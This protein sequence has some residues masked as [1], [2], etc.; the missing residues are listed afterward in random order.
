MAKSKNRDYPLSETPKPN[1]EVYG[2]GSNKNY[3]MGVSVDVPIYK[4]LSV[5]ANKFYGKDDYGN[6]F[7]NT[8]YNA[9]IRIPL[10]KN[11][12]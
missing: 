5:G 3:Q 11:K 6:K 12:K 10:R 8:S 7:K 2:R 4:G 9:T 1:V